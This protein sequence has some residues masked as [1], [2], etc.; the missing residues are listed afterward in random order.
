MSGLVLKDLLSLRRYLKS[1]AAFLLIYDIIFIAVDQASSAI[2][3]TIFILASLHLSAAA[4]DESSRWDGYAQSLPVTHS[5]IVLSRYL[6][7]GISSLAGLIVGS[8]LF[9]VNIAVHGFT[10]EQIAASFGA[11]LAVIPVT[12]LVQI[13]TLPLIYRFG[14]QRARL[15]IVLGYALAVALLI[16]SVPFLTGALSTIGSITLGAVAVVLILVV[17]TVVSFRISCRIYEARR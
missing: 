13:F 16:L 7:A 4:Y 1:S 8:I 11:I 15:F 17:G 9:A 2:G 5:Q 14:V 12:I 6:T 3:V 10:Q